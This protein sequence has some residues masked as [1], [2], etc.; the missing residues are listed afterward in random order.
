M[1]I[2]PSDSSS[3]LGRRQVAVRF[4]IPVIL[5]SMLILAFWGFQ[6]YYYQQRVGRLAS[7][8]TK[9]ERDVIEPSG[10]VRDG[11]R[12]NCPHWLDTVGLLDVTCPELIR[13][14]D[15]LVIPG[16]E[17][18]LMDKIIQVEGF[19]PGVHSQLADEMLYGGSKNG[20]VFNLTLYPIA[21]G[22]EPYTAPKGKE[23]KSLG[24]SAYYVNR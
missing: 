24:L 4:G 2:K 9:A 14:W 17:Y 23:W 3:S 16:N 22:K 13:S 18:D 21:Q 6:E 5:I 8:V 1:K 19:R 20:I 10:A 7:V 15:I 11:G 12:S